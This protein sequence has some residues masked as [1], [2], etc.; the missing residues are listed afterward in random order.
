M[1]VEQQTQQPY[2]VVIAF[3][4]LA[5]LVAFAGLLLAY[6]SSQQWQYLVLTGLG[7][8]VVAV[9]GVAYWIARFR[10]RYS[11]GI[12]L[13]AGI[14]IV[15]TI[16]I[17]LFVSDFWYLA[18]FLL[19]VI[20]V[21]VGVADRL[22]RIPVFLV[23]DLLGASAMVAS[24]LLAP[25]DRIN[26]LGETQ[27]L[28]VLLT[29]A[30]VA[31]LA[32]TLFLLWYYR[33]RSQS[34]HY[35]RVDLATQQS[36]IFATIFALSIVLV[37]GV[38]MV[39]ISNN[40]IE[41]IGQNFENVA[42]IYGERMA[43]VL[44]QQVKDLSSLVRLESI[45]IEGL[46]QSN[47]SYPASDS[48]RTAYREELA[49]RWQT[50]ADMDTFVLDIR[51]NDMT[52]AL[53]RFRGDALNHQ[54]V[55]VTNRYGDLV[56]AQGERPAAFSYDDQTWWQTAWNYGQGGVY[57]G[58]LQLGSGG[59][60]TS[61]RIAVGMIN[62]QTNETVGVVESTFLLRNMQQDLQ[63]ANDQ[64][65]GTLLL[66]SADSKIIAGPTDDEIGT[67]IY[68]DFAR[69]LPLGQGIF[70]AGWLLGVDYED[71]PAV[72]GIAPLINTE[73]VRL[74]VPRGLGWTVV[75]SDTQTNALADV[76]RSIK[77]AGL[78]GLFVTGLGTLAAVALA[79]VITRPIEDLTQTATLITAGNLD[80][81][82]RPVGPIELRTLAEAFNSLTSQLQHLINNLQDQVAQRTSQLESR[83]EQLATL[84]RITQAIASV[85]NIDQASQTVASEMVML[86][87]A[88]DC[89]IALLDDDQTGLTIVANYS[90]DKS[91]PDPAGG[92]ITL[93]NNPSSS[94]VVMKGELVVV[95][96]AQHSP[97]TEPIHELLGQMRT[98]CLMIVPLLVRGEVIGTIAV[99]T[100]DPVRVFTAAEVSLAETVAGQSLARLRAPACIHRRKKRARRL[101]PRTKPRVRSW[102]M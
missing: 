78:A 44:D 101:R 11:Q 77:I 27:L 61:V 56:A 83:V 72:L 39:Q 80:R 2:W 45:L 95:S 20:P 67:Q 18:I 100:D 13:V 26:A 75:V 37:T 74:D 17:P 66:L 42:E 99:S 31:Y 62:P 4:T 47:M 8:A 28:A 88:H 53:S 10:Q 9:H 71:R 65:P 94:Q 51:S 68:E 52:F 6:L 58:D 64:I 22:R 70:D 63:I 12:W 50:S 59:A 96:D 14:K 38:L 23:L 91:L 49:R 85:H 90:P 1:D 21:E 79:R 55:F 87:D 36:L 32:L 57:V 54:N 7:A 41:Q 34:P 82:A 35:A 30:L 3:S 92:F 102:P 15:A 40:Q 86:F 33:L 97:L 81:Q 24:D 5:S 43:N 25:G 93:E 84:N 89:G 16:L 73:G 69:E 29:T 46:T 48:E 19:A 76:I 60:K 98:E